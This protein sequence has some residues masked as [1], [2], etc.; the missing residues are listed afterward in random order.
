M[1]FVA[2]ATGTTPAR[3]SPGAGV[4]NEI[5]R[6]K[7][8]ELAPVVE[9]HLSLQQ[10]PVHSD[11]LPGVAGG[12]LVMHTRDRYRVIVGHLAL[13]ADQETL[14]ERIVVLREAQRLGIGVKALVG[15]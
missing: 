9:E 10:L 5:H 6:L 8:D 15:R 12:D 14:A 11:R 3:S 1:N 4:G 13:E 2:V 7:F